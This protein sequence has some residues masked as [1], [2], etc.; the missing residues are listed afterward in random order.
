MKIKW[1]K[2]ILEN[3]DQAAHIYNA[4]ATLQRDIAWR[5]SKLCSQQSIPKGLW[6]D[7]GSG[8][9]LLAESLE[10]LNPNQEVL[11][12]DSS[13][14]MIDLQKSSAKKQIWDLNNGLPILSGPPQLIA[15]SFALHWLNHP[16]ERIKEWFN[17]LDNGGWLALAIPINGSFAEW[18]EASNKANVPCTALEL[19]ST[20]DLVN[21]IDSKNI[22]HSQLIHTIQRSDGLTSLFKTMINIGAQASKYPSIK[23]SQWKRL[24]KAW[25]LTTNKEV[26]LTWLI[27]LLLI[28]K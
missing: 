1:Q 19:P 20:D 2:K 10:S 11:R 8:T 17:V 26:S 25:P 18:Y 21:S 9:G 24:Q 3:F 28:Q 27:Q 7:L 12:I 5:L 4:N 6:L 22:Q 14:K 15:S 16:C 13:K 23:P